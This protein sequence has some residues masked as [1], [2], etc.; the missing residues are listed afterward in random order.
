MPA[1][2]QPAAP[3]LRRLP[4][5]SGER[6][7]R[8]EPRLGVGGLPPPSESSQ[9][10]RRRDLERERSIVTP[11]PRVGLGAV[12]RVAVGPVDLRAL[13]LDHREGFI[14]S[15]IDGDTNLATLIDLSGMDPDEV[16]RIVDRLLTLGAILIG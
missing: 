13:P 15:L 7:R 9:L 2:K 5:G 16:T 14:L 3:P 12:L 6:E 1:K 8:L 10:R 4:N 11:R